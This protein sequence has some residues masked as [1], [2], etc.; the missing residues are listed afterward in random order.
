MRSI[1]EETRPCVEFTNNAQTCP[2][3]EKD[4]SRL[5]KIIDERP[6]LIMK[7]PLLSVND[8]SLQFDEEDFRECSNVFD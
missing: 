3:I 2:I 7:G 6:D 4:Q 5:M 1:R 8:S